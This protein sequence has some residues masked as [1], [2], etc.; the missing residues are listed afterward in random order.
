[1]P[2][3][4]DKQFLERLMQ[5]K[6]LKKKKV[7]ASPVTESSLS[8]AIFMRFFFYPLRLT[9]RLMCRLRKSSRTGTSARQSRHNCS[10]VPS[11]L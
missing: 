2:K 9:L 8:R 1:M 11:I 4:D 10:K 5:A 6:I 3:G 7:S